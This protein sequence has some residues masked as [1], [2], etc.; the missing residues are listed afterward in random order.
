MKECERVAQNILNNVYTPISDYTEGSPTKV[1]PLH[2]RE[3]IEKAHIIESFSRDLIISK[4]GSEIKEALEKVIQNEQNEMT[5]LLN[6]MSELKMKINEE[7]TLP[8]EKEQYYTIDGFEDKVTDLPM[9]YPWECSKEDTTG[10]VG[11]TTPDERNKMRSEYNS[12][13]SRLVSC[14][15]E[16]VM[17]N[18]MIN[19]FQDKKSYD[20]NV[21]QA[22]IL[23]F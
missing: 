21:R 5:S 2:E 1:F 17:L 8:A 6:K 20:L 4:K 3:N 12:A 22:A 19:N 9:F 14:K 7:P 11:D 15:V 16:V 10:Y 13:A 23:G 18:T